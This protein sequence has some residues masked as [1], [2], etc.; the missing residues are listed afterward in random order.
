MRS[1]T[2]YLA[3]L[4]A[5]MLFAAPSLTLSIAQA[6]SS[7]ADGTAWNQWRGPDRDGLSKETGL[8]KDWE[9]QRPKL[10]WMSDRMGT[11]YAGLAIA[12]GRIF[13][14]GN[15][16]GGQAVVAANQEDGKVIWRRV[17]T[18]QVPKHGYQGS[19]CTPTVDGDRLF[20]ML[21]DGTIACLQTDDGKVVWKR[22]AKDWNGKMM[23]SWG[24]SESPLV[25]GN[26]VI[27]TPGGPDA[28][29][30][31]LNK[32]TGKEIWKSAV[33]N[34]GD[35]GKDGA[36]Y[37]SAIISNGAGVKQYV[38]LTGR[39]LIGVRAK[40][41]KFLW[42]YNPVANP[43]ANIPTPIASGDY[44]FGTSGY[45]TGA[46]LLKLSRA[47]RGGVKAEEV[48]FLPAKTF[49]NH[50]GG[51]LLVGD[52]LYAGHK[53]NNGFPICLD[54]K[55][56]DVVW[57]GDIRGPGKGSAAVLYADGHLIF[58]YQDG[59]LALIE[60]TPEEYRLKGTLKPAFQERESWS[61]PVIVDGKLYLREQDKLM[62]YDL[63]E[64]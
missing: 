7:G 5:A 46:A 15:S 58:R 33:P 37:S 56:G 40:D 31:A 6:G 39:G 49:Q 23:S 62:C 38:Q 48:Y 3:G 42:G 63:K 22:H 43:T 13:T 19:R 41:G 28:M 36:G 50:H 9:T 57:G 52:H 17:L 45:G 8:S 1:R 30:V 21:S 32:R 4:S 25:D 11:G 24:Y 10:L 55:S 26:K 18:D 54:M 20:V 14:T 53:H 47:P 35:N 60:A 61:H 51:V 16:D 34:L 44:V 12:D 2:L 64:S 59:T 27:V 29:M